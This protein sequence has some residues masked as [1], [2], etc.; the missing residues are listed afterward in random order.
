[1]KKKLLIFVLFIAV[2]LLIAM[3]IFGFY[4]NLLIK[5][6]VE[7]E[8]DVLWKMEQMDIYDEDNIVPF[9]DIKINF[10]KKEEYIKICVD[11]NSCNN[12][13]YRQKNQK[14]YIYYDDKS[15]FGGYNYTIEHK[16][17]NLLL[18]KEASEESK[19]KIIYYFKK[20]N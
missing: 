12:V 11:N 4:N 15:T 19:Y 7:I 1:M 20:V 14:I 18:I 10:I 13:K 17:N 8:N 9:Y 16:K 5:K 6:N 3:I 2:L